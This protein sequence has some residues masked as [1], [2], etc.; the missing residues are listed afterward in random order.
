MIYVNRN[1]ELTIV[2]L[3]TWPDYLIENFKRDS[4]AAFRAILAALR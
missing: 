1:A 4:F 3:S 2:K